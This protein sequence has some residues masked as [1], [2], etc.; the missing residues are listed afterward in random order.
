MNHSTGDL[1]DQA[2][3]HRTTSRT[4]GVQSIT[5]SGAS[6]RFIIERRSRLIK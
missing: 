5:T 3:A 4:K 6:D 1:G 2:P